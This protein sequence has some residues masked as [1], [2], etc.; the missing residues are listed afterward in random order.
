MLILSSIELSRR[1]FVASSAILALSLS[2]CAG[3]TPRARFAH[4]QLV[5]P[6]LDAYRPVLDGLIQSFLP[7][8]DP[9]FP[10]L[11][12]EAARSELLTLFPIEEDPRFLTL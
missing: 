10:A 3:W 12:M 4:T 2:G 5:D 8:D 6:P 9:S 11:S 1:E 7:F